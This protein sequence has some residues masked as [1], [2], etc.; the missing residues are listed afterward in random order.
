MKKFLLKVLLIV[1]GAAVLFFCIK[2]A[3]DPNG[4]MNR[5]VTPTPTVTKADPVVLVKEIQKLSRLETASVDSEQII[6]GERN[7]SQFWGAF[8]ESM[9]FVA[10]GQVIAGIDL[11]NF[12]KDDVTIVDPTTINIK[13]PAAEILSVTIDNQKSYVEDRNAGLFANSDKNLESEVR[14]KAEID[15]KANAL[16]QGILDKADTNAKSVIKDFLTSYGFKQV[17]FS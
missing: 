10:Y 4:Y 16:N 13:L 7:Q 9:S 15:C 8:G 12:T 11:G 5:L 17:N 1:F 14:Q 3:V 2:Q 6:K